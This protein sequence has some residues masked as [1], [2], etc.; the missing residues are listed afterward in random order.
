MIMHKNTTYMIIV[1]ISALATINAANLLLKYEFDETINVI[2][3]IIDIDIIT[4]TM[5]NSGFKDS[6]V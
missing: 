6:S 2:I 4:E 1:I 3:V 5:D